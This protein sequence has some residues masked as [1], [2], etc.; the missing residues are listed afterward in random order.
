MNFAKILLVDDDRVSLRLLDN[1]LKSES[2]QTVTFSKVEDAMNYLLEG[3][4]QPDLIISD[5]F[6]PGIS[7]LEFLDQVK[8]RTEFAAI[9]FLFISANKNEKIETDAFQYGAIDFLKKPI[10]KQLLLNKINALLQ[11]LGSFSLN[12]NR[13]FE[14]DSSMMNIHEIISYCEEEKLDGFALIV[15]DQQHGILT[16]A[17]GILETI[18]YDNLNDSDAL[19]NMEG[20]ESYQIFIFR[21]KVN[22]NVIQSFFKRKAPPVREL[23]KNISLDKIKGKLPT[24]K[25]NDLTLMLNELSN[26]FE[27]IGVT[28]NDNWIS[29]TIT[30]NDDKL[31]KLKKDSTN[32]IIADF[33]S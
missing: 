29:S 7:G 17:K 10:N 18:Q 14:G 3:D 8:S 33:S 26:V 16:F 22:N 31:I 23:K 28:L 5:Y 13:V 12:A 21:G 2:Y 4:V 25:F 20:L 1:I 30:L 19:E 15:H 27:K 9:P 11:S 6:M 32:S 24:D